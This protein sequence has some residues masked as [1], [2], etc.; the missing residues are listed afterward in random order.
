MAQ[1]SNSDGRKRTLV[2][3]LTWG[4]NAHARVLSDCRLFE[5]ER[6]GRATGVDVCFHSFS[7]GPPTIG[8]LWICGQ[9]IRP[10][11]GTLR[12]TPRVHSIVLERKVEIAVLFDGLIEDC[13]E[14]D[15]NLHTI[16]GTRP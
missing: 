3:I 1:R 14:E 8:P 5:A 4:Q 15:L 16:A 11:F 13:P 10:A 12:G 9:K 6:D 2:P 7:P